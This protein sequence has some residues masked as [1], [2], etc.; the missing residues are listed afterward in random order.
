MDEWMN[1]PKLHNLD[2]LKL[3]LI[4]SALLSSSGKS[5]N[6]LAPV[7]MS[8]ITKANKNGIRF[9]TDE[10]KLIMELMKQGKSEAE[11]AKIDKTAKLAETFLKR[12]H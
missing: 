4:K 7:L 12:K 9:N 5:G 8:L 6:D 2:P 1:N 3:E 11:K 10:I